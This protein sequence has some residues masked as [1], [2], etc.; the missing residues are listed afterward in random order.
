MRNPLL[1]TL[2]CL[3]DAKTLGFPA[4]RMEI[5]EEALDA[6]PATPTRCLARGA[7]G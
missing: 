6:L 7:G 1:P 3:N 2:L 5:Y 4:L